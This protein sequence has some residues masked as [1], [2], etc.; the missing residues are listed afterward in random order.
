MFE[1][2]T[3]VLFFQTLLLP[4]TSLEPVIG[5]DEGGSRRRNDTRSNP[6]G[7]FSE[8]SMRRLGTL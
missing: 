5:L 8:A 2:L 4:E 7:R 1:I 6:M 3:F